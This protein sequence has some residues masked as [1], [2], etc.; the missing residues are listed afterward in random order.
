[1]GQ[2]TILLALTQEVD[3]VLDFSDFLGRKIAHL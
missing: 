3:E 1:V 2:S